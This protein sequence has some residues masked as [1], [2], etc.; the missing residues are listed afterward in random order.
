MYSPLFLNLIV[1]ESDWIIASVKCQ[2]KLRVG[3]GARETG[4]MIAIELGVRRENPK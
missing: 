4:R 1:T 3:S 2:G